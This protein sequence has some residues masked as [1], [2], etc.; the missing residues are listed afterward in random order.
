MG[1]GKTFSH[2][3]EWALWKDMTAIGWRTALYASLGA[4]IFG[5][6]TAWWSG[7]LGMPAFTSRYGIF[8]PVTQKYAISPPHQSSGKRYPSIY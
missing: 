5:Y 8:N 2:P 1:S 4:M 3:R 7:V 6:D